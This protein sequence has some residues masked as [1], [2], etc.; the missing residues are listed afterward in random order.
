MGGLTNQGSGTVTSGGLTA[1]SSGTSES[2]TITAANAFPQVSSGNGTTFKFADP[3]LTSEIMMATAAPGGTGAGQ[4]WTVTRGAESTIPVVH[5]AG[6]A[7]SELITAAVI[8]TKA[9]SVQAIQPGS[10]PPAMETWHNVTPPTGWSG[11]N[12]YKLVAEANCVLIDIQCTHAGASGNI[13]F[14]TLPAGYAPASQHS[15]IPA[16]GCNSAP[17]NS[18]QR[19]DVNTAG[20]VVTFSLPSSTTLVKVF[21]ICPLD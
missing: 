13:T 19:I 21:M 1:P 3:A 20:T 11:I 4:A 10:S 9:G 16:I 5:S 15:T 17:A 12:R 6:F 18:N 8:T 2:W 14:M 7:I